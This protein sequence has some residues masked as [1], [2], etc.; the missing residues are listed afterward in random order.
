MK[1]RSGCSTGTGSNPIDGVIVGS[2]WSPAKSS[3]AARSAKTKWPWV[4]P[5]VC[6]ASS[7]RV[8]T[9]IVWSPSSQ[10]SG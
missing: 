3:P 4:C 6:T 10:V 5:G 2:T 7:V 1:S 8:P 9:S